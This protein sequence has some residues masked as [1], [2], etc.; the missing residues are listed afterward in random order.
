[1]DE[2]I[3]LIIF[4]STKGLVPDF[5]SFT[6]KLDNPEIIITCTVGF[7]I[8]GYRIT[9]VGGLDE[10][11][12]IIS[13]TSTEGLIPNF[14]APAVQLNKPEISS[15]CTVGFGISGYRITAVG[16]LDEGICPIVSTSSEGLIPELITPAIQ[17]YYPEIMVTRTVGS[18]ISS[19][20]ITAVDGLDEEICLII[21]NSTKSLIPDFITPAVQLYYPEITPTSTVG[22]GKSCYRITAVDGLDEGICP[23]ICNSTKSLIPDFITPAVQFY[24][25]EIIVTRTVGNGPSCYRITAVGGLDE[26]ICLIIFNSTKSLIPDFITPAVQLYYPEI[27]A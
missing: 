9:A 1:L 18:G 21:F 20:R 22:N 7:G 15:S 19:N 8:S 24:Y 27:T 4:I 10:G 25:P 5:I 11:K 26:G 3:Y 17:F 23:I 12:C 14:I 16:G 13:I 2:G 6:V